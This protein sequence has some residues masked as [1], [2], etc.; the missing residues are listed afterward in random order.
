MAYGQIL[1]KEGLI[2]EDVT[3]YAITKFVLKQAVDSFKDQLKK[4]AQDSQDINTV[5]TKA[6]NT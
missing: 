4:V 1:A 2:K 3:P 5:P 6:L